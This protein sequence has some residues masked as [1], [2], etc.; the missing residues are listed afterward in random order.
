VYQI[1]QRLDD[2]IIEN[3]DQ[4]LIVPEGEAHSVFGRLKVSARRPGVKNLQG[5]ITKLQQLR[6][7]GI[8]KGHM[9]EWHLLKQLA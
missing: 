9:M 8:S 7:V 5:E 1:T 4:L 6:S 3:I 2:K